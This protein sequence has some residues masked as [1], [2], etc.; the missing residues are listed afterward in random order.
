[1]AYGYDTMGNKRGAILSKRYVTTYNGLDYYELKSRNLHRISPLTP[2]LNSPAPETPSN[3]NPDNCK[4][5][6]FWRRRGGGD[7]SVCCS[8][9][10]GAKIKP[11]M[12]PDPGKTAK[13]YG[14]A[15][16]GER[17]AA[18]RREMILGLVYDLIPGGSRYGGIARN[19]SIDFNGQD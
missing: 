4:P 6:W 2:S 16:R 18:L 9:Y 14:A 1:M 19:Q 5:H 13:I 11:P 10:G 7:S 17:P 3:H 15:E 12:L 8:K